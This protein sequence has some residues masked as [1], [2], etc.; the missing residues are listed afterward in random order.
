MLDY[1]IVLNLWFK[2]SKLLAADF[3]FSSFQI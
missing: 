1:L 2:K 3:L